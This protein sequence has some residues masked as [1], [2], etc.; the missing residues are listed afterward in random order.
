VLAPSATTHTNMG[1]S[2][3]GLRWGVFAPSG[4]SSQAHVNSIRAFAVSKANSIWMNRQEAR[5]DRP[6]GCPGR[7]TRTRIQRYSFRLFASTGSAVLTIKQIAHR[8][9]AG[10]VGSLVR[11]P[12]IPGRCAGIAGFLFA[13]L[14]TTIGKPGL[15]RL[16]L[17]L[18]TASHASFDRKCHFKYDTSCRSQV[19]HLLPKKRGRNLRSKGVSPMQ[20]GK[21]PVESS[22]ERVFSLRPFRAALIVANF[23]GL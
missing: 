20:R 19:V 6:L 12:L 23:A 10:G 7:R 1:Q 14:R 16:Q 13:A 8:L 22:I 21:V 2:F 17:K 15:P 9:T 18:L 4:I 5:R 3:I 11:L